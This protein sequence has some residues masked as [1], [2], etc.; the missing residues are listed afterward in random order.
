MRRH[1]PCQRTADRF[2]PVT[3]CDDADMTFRISHSKQKSPPP[4]GT[5]ALAAMFLA[6]CIHQPVH[7]QAGADCV[8]GGTVQQSNACAIKDFQ[9]ADTDSNILYGDVMRSLSA[10]ERPALRKEQNEWTRGRNTQC[11]KSQAAFEAQA[12]WPRRFHECLVQQIKD[13]DAVLKQWLHH[14]GPL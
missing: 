9:Q 7:A 8:P 14:G 13:R 2:R 12:D 5:Q 6:A 4:L 3:A 11:K 1:R 10:H